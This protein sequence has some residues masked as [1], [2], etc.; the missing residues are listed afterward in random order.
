MGLSVVDRR[1]GTNIA[2]LING[3]EIKGKPKGIFEAKPENMNLVNTLTMSD[4][5]L[6]VIEI[7]VRVVVRIMPVRNVPITGE[8]TEGI[9]IARMPFEIGLKDIRPS[10]GINRRKVKL[11]KV[12]IRII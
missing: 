7:V 3:V 4:D 5:L 6:D 2:G 10:A 12:R 8:D 9:L 1:D 11:D